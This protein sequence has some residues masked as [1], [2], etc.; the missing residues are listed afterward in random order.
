M[1]ISEEIPKELVGLKEDIKPRIIL[2]PKEPKKGGLLEIRVK[3]EHPQDPGGRV[4]KATGKAMP[5]H[6]ITVM[7]AS[8]GGE[9][10]CSYDCTTGLSNDPIFGFMLMVDKPGTLKVEME[11]NIG[12]KFENMVEI[13]V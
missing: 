9:P 6:Y 8:Y 13:K 7:K 3:L 12:N 1:E 4:D 5:R 10:L 11:C 2:K